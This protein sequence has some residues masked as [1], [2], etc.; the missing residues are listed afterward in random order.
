MK[1]LNS[2]A[3]PYRAI[4]VGSSGGLGGAF[5][6]L[7]DADPR[8]REAVGLGR[9]SE[10]RLD[11]EDEPTIE[12][13][14]SF[15]AATGPVHLIIDAT[16]ILHDGTMQ[17]EKSINVADPQMI[18]RA[19]A[20]NATGPLLL[21]KHFHHLMPRNERSVFATISARVGSITDN[22]LGGWYGYRASK[23]ALNMMIRTASVEITRKRPA[24]VCLALHPGT[25]KTKLSDPFS[26]QRDRLDPDRA[27]AMLLDVIDQAESCATG[28][29]LAYDGTEIPW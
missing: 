29:F 6:R 24:A 19:F 15:V 28:S 7:L 9:A 5:K 10:P 16:G 13:A 17:P 11:L 1:S 3:G 21:L 27:A 23:A 12:Q 26:N 18:A 22:R 25:V 8:C 20:I 4:V 2:F 14:A